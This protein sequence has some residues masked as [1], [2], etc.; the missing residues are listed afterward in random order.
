M[1]KYAGQSK[2]KDLEENGTPGLRPPA[3]FEAIQ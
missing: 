2:G 3:T 1:E